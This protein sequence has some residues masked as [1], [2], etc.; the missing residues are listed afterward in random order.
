MAHPK[1]VCD[2]ALVNTWKTLPLSL[3]CV[4]V[5]NRANSFAGVTQR[6]QLTGYTAVA[7]F[8]DEKYGIFNHDHV[9]LF[10]REISVDPAP[11]GMIVMNPWAE[12]KDEHGKVL[13][14]AH[15]HPERLNMSYPLR[16]KKGYVKPILP[17]FSYV[18]FFHNIV[19]SQTIKFILFN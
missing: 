2:Q 11:D 17:L 1:S 16:I 15:P 6:T 8:Q 10:V 4:E 14:Q 7:S 5:W 19:V 13:R 12:L 3:E 9:A 18:I